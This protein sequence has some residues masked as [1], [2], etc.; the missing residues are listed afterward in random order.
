MRQATRLQDEAA[1]GRERRYKVL[2]NGRRVRVSIELKSPNHAVWAYLRW[3]SEGKTRNVY[4]GRVK[5]EDRLAQLRDGWRL[6]RE[7]GLV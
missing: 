7:K 6:A 1:G 5:G 4:V 2:Q 3:H